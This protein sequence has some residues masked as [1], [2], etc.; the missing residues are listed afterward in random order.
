MKNETRTS[1]SPSSLTRCV[2]IVIQYYPNICTIY[3]LIIIR[4][5]AK[6]DHQN[7]I[8]LYF[9]IVKRER[10]WNQCIYSTRDLYMFHVSFCYK[11]LENYYVFFLVWH[12][13]GCSIFGVVV[14]HALHVHDKCTLADFIAVIN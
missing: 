2:C 1:T 12:L 7:K 9:I 8:L 4:F 5:L 10:V 11:S 14:G 13:N 3:F 6:Q